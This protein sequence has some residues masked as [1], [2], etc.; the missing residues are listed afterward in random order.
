[1]PPL[2][3]LSGVEARYGSL[4]VVRDVTFAVP[5]TSFCAILGPNGAGKTT[6]LKMIA[7]LVRPSAGTIVFD[8][9]RIDALGPHEIARRGV[10]LVPEGRAIFPSLTVDENLAL[11]G[12]ERGRI[13]HLFPVLG[14]RAGQPAGTLSGGEQRMLSLSRALASPPRLLLLDEPSLGLAPLVVRELFDVIAALREQGITIVLVEQQVPRAL[15]L[16][17]YVYVLANGELAFAGEAE[18]VR[19]DAALRR[20]YL[21]S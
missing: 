14:E 20:A 10:V 21:G 2:L 3:S 18:E 8:G 15:S 13:T 7:G 4:R 11:T 17:E 6:I 12:G 5:E 1:M 19:R 9:R 16:A